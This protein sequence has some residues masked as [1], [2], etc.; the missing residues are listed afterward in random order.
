MD[1]TMKTRLWA[2]VAALLLV[3]AGAG[4]HFASPALALSG[5][6]DALVEGDRNDINER[7]D[8]PAVRDSMKGQATAFVTAKMAEQKDN[9]FSALGQMMAMSMIN[10]MI[11]GMMTPDG[12]KAI[13]QQGHFNDPN[14][15]APPA[16]AG[17]KPVEW[18][19]TRSAFD[20][21]TAR[22][23]GA[24][25]N[26]APQLVFKRDGLG[27]KLVD[28]RMPEPDPQATAIPEGQ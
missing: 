27:W 1:M 20:K 13:M 7:I 24:E 28:I 11:D 12:L 2:I 21:F 15:A 22:P 3:A 10:T 26:N 9:P 6:R 16:T 25:V 4:W 19:I 14:K 17:A 5:L 23:V 8:F 18:Q